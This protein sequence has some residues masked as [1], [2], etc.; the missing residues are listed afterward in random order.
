MQ[1]SM[2]GSHGHSGH[3]HAQLVDTLLACAMA[4]EFCAAS[5]LHEDDVKMMARCIELDRDCADIC[6]L[7]AEM[8]TRDSMHAHKLLALCAEICEAARL[9][10]RNT[11]MT[12]AKHVQKL[13]TSALKPAA[14]MPGNNCSGSD[15]PD[16]VA[17]GVLN[18]KMIFAA[19]PA[20]EIRKQ[21]YSLAN[22]MVI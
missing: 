11:R 15:K 8:L 21:G 13:A 22:G 3:K 12:I 2:S 5:C 1:S 20:G 19:T 10:V 17:I 7:A 18:G 6:M 4:C 16:S 9:N 14:H